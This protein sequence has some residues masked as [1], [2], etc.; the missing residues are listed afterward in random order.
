MKKEIR[1]I[2]CGA[3]RVGREFLKLLDERAEMIESKYGIRPVLSAVAESDG[4]AVSDGGNGLSIAGLLKHLQNGGTVPDFPIFGVSL[5]AGPQVIQEIKAD[6]IIEATPTNLS[7]A[8]PGMTNVTAAL[9]NGLDVISANKGPFV[10]F[11]REVRELAREHDCSVHLSAATAAALPTLDVGLR[12]LAGS[13][14]LSVEGILNG[15]TNFI[16]TKMEISGCRYE[17]ALLEAQEL[18]IAEKDP[19]YDI[20]GLDT[21]NKLI[22]ISN[23]IFDT[24]YSLGDVDVCGISRIGQEDID[25][26]AKR[27]ES[28]KLIG[29]IQ[30]SEKGIVLRVAPEAIKRS[31]PLANVSGSEK[32]VSYL[33][34]TMDR[35]T[36]SGGKSSPVGAAAALLKDLINAYS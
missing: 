24:D 35:I 17:E 2:L 6:V 12:S 10:L 32:A 36:V 11:F 16:L 4:A 29:S 23:L 14:V 8:E 31:H 28:I 5:M 26:A 34:D 13:T 30:T 7:D 3:G 22:L 25:G 15:T 18:G 20:D 19:R 21:A 9:K 1:I 33:T 27:G